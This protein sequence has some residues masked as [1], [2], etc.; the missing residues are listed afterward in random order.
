M[1][2]NDEINELWQAQSNLKLDGIP[3]QE[4]TNTL[5]RSSHFENT[6][7]KVNK[8]E[9]QEKYIRSTS[10][11]YKKDVLEANKT[12][13]QHYIDIKIRESEN[14][15]KD[16]TNLKNKANQNELKIRTVLLYMLKKP[17]LVLQ[18]NL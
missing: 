7:S 16:I 17:E 8:Y 12:F 18:K 2:K 10:K 13:Y 9:I 1:L 6:G 15:I 14:L 4:K 5:S 11:K 3:L